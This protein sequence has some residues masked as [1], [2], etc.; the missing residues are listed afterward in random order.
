VSCQNATEQLKSAV[1]VT[2]TSVTSN[3][4]PIVKSDDVLWP[5]GRTDIETGFIRSS[6]R[7]RPKKSQNWKIIGLFVRMNGRHRRY[8]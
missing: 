1:F 2:R 8:C 5:D 3:S 6:G 4:D 7:S